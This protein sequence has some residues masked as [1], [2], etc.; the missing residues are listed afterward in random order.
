ME[1]YRCFV[2]GCSNPVNGYCDCTDVSILMCKNHYF[3][4]ST[5]KSPRGHNWF[6]LDGNHKKLILNHSIWGFLCSLN[7]AKY[8]AI[9]ETID[10]S[11][12]L[13]NSLDILLKEFDKAKED[14][15]NFLNS[16]ND[17]SKSENLTENL[18]TISFDIL[19]DYMQE[20]KI[21]IPEESIDLKNEIC[22]YFDWNIYNPRLSASNLGQ[23][24]IRLAENNQ[25]FNQFSMV[26]IDTS[27]VYPQHEFQNTW[28][29]QNP[30]IAYVEN[31]EETQKKQQI[32]LQISLD[33][34]LSQNLMYSTEN[35]ADNI[36]LDLYIPQESN[37]QINYG[38]SLPNLI[39]DMNSKINLQENINLRNP[40]QNTEN[41]RFQRIDHKNHIQG[42]GYNIHLPNPFNMHQN[43]PANLSALGSSNHDVSIISEPAR[44]KSSTKP[45]KINEMTQFPTRNYD[46]MV[47]LRLNNPPSHHKLLNSGSK[48]GKNTDR[49]IY[50]PEY[51][52]QHMKKFSYNPEMI[53]RAPYVMENRKCTQC[54]ENRMHYTNSCGCL[55]CNRCTIKNIRK[56]RCK[57]CPRKYT[58]SRQSLFNDLEKLNIFTKLTKCDE[59]GGNCQTISPVFILTMKMCNVCITCKSIHLKKCK[60]CELTVNSIVMGNPNF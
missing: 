28:I 14:T 29:S 60:K 1:N 20:W 4:H 36:Y 23:Y 44:R 48:S 16:L 35:V 19:N 53:S 54:D 45:S 59:H 55:L 12:L 22:K 6:D 39:N 5:K 50:D 8:Q 15:Q 10:L 25:I 13:L 17:E 58:E 40:Y 26:P 33:E 56:R 3:E 42:A 46:Q 32:E 41:E 24:L 34:Q 31:P 51:N 52:I 37:N 11:N 9:K 7:S 57:K 21:K 49:N 30:S 2:V 38:D 43:S 18:G 47:N 27:Q